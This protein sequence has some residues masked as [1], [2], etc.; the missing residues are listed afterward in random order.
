MGFG[1][2]A[3]KRGAYAVRAALVL[4]L[5]SSCLDASSA[6]AESCKPTCKGKSGACIG[7]AKSLRQVERIDCLAEGEDCRE[8][9]LVDDEPCRRLCTSES[10]RCE[11]GA[12]WK[13][14][15]S[16]DLCKS[17]SVACTQECAPV[18]ADCG[19]ACKKSQRSCTQNA[20]STARTCKRE[21]CRAAESR[22]ACIRACNR[23]FHAA[24]TGCATAGEGCFESCLAG[25]PAP[26]PT[27]RPPSAT[28]TPGQP[29]PSSAVCDPFEP[30]PSSTLS[31]PLADRSPSCCTLQL[32]LVPGTDFMLGA[33]ALELGNPAFSMA[34][35]RG[36]N[37]RTD[38]L[39][40]GPSH[41]EHTFLG[42]QPQPD[43]DGTFY[44]GSGHLCQGWSLP[45]AESM[46]AHIDAN[47]GHTP[48]IWWPTV[49]DRRTGTPLRFSGQRT[50][51]YYVGH[52]SLGHDMDRRFHLLP[53]GAGYV[54][55]VHRFTESNGRARLH[56]R[57]PTAFHRDITIGRIDDPQ[58][59]DPFLWFPG[60]G[61]IPPESEGWFQTPQ[62]QVY[63][64]FADLGTGD[65]LRSIASFGGP[66]T[67]VAPHLDYV[68]AASPIPNGSNLGQFHID[69]TLN[70]PGGGN[71][72]VANAI[73][74]D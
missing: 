51:V 55:Q 12:L 46:P 40:A 4:V 34:I 29:P 57:G 58:Q 42:I 24:A 44:A 62:L 15:D 18:G 41:H 61:P 63:L 23:E 19:R 9:C 27:P 71:N 38:L 68:S 47:N 52:A 74:R 25:A 60:D 33:H 21:S 20:K 1:D 10:Y 49:Y 36:A 28:P 73:Y 72:K 43:P 69:V 66:D 70:D 37:A 59:N 39:V 8:S 3:Q 54:S 30:L 64:I 11:L 45:G 17:E 56:F 22:S 67:S 16:R 5:S 14:E 35:P 32:G 65:E 48:L 6:L 26:T 50:S 13:Y 7:G 2:I 31:P 53:N